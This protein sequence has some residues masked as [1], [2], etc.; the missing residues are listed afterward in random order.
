MKSFKNLSKTDMSFSSSK[1]K[2]LEDAV[3]TLLESTS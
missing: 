1:I 2:E 3:R